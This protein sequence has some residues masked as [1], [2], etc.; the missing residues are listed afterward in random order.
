MVSS[1]TF[2]LEKENNYLLEPIANKHHV[3]SDLLK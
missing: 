1:I 2:E 3:L